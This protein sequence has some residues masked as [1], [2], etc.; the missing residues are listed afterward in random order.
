MR[1]T[2]ELALV[3]V[4]PAGG[5]GSGVPTEEER[6]TDPTPHSE[7][8]GKPGASLSSSDPLAASVSASVHNATAPA[9]KYGPSTPLS[10]A[11][12]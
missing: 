6:V 3:E 2:S 4:P 7:K 12:G 10:S 9:D 8:V 1:K 11:G 5:V